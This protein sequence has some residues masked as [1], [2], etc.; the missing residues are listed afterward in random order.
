VSVKYSAAV[1]GSPPKAGSLCLT[2]LLFRFEGV[3]PQAHDRVDL[4]VAK[5]AD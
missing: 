2:S 5:I 4:S 3:I 1:V